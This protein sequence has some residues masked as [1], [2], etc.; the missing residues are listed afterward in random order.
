MALA[1]A[2]S[3]DAMAAPPAAPTLA[4]GSRVSIRSNDFKQRVVGRVESI[5]E[6]AI[7]VARGKRADRIPW[8][9]VSR[10]DLQVGSRRPFVEATLLGGAVGAFVGLIN[11]VPFECNIIRP[12]GSGCPRAPI[13]P[14]ALKGALAGLLSTFLMKPFVPRWARLPPPYP[15]GR[16]GVSYRLEPTLGGVSARL[17]LSF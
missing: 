1:S 7:T 16:G 11:P 5:D 3:A 9:S 4:V 15:P 10:L 8:A 14:I 17:V 12:P 6:A 2:A 13:A